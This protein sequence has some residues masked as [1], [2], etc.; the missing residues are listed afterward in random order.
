MTNFNVYTPANAPEKSKGLLKGWL[1]KLG[2]V[3][4]VIGVMAESPALLKGYAELNGAYEGG[5]L[6]PVE[7]MIVKLSISSLNGCGYCVAGY[8]TAW[9][10]EGLPKDVLESLRAEKPLKDGKLEALRVF[11]VSV[12][13]KLGRV[14]KHDLELFY[15]AGYT[16]AY[17][18]DVVLGWSVANIGNYVNHIAQPEL[19]KQFEGQRFVGGG[20]HGGEKV[21]GGKSHVA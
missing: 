5:V 7:R 9:L 17:V 20:K 8:S 19:D 14:D 1:E 12:A 10:K 15:K 16:K 18:L 21:V 11:T 4:N 2:F 3:P 6:S 13:K